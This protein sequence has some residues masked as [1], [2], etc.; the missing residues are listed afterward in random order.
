MYQSNT[1][2][3]A[4]SHTLSSSLLDAAMQVD[5]SKLADYLQQKAPAFLQVRSVHKDSNLHHVACT[6]QMV[7]LCIDCPLP[8]RC[9]FMSKKYV[10]KY[11]NHHHVACTARMILCVKCTWPHRCSFMSKKANEAGCKPQAAACWQS[12]PQLC[13]SCF[14]TT[15]PRAGTKRWWTLMTTST[16]WKSELLRGIRSS[17]AAVSPTCLRRN[18]HSLCR[19]W[20]NTLLLS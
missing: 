12:K 9:S 1:L 5:N 14:W 13:R 7:F 15:T 8:P 2:L 17:S 4:G 19:D 20:F 11:G 10:D 6:A 16:T 3:A 18:Y